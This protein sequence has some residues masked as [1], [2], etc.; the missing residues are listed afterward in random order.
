MTI[1]AGLGLV[2]PVLGLDELIVRRNLAADHGSQAV[3]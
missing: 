2:L 1:Y 3:H